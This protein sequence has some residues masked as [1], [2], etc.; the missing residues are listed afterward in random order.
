MARSGRKNVL[1]L[2]GEFSLMT[3]Y[4]LVQDELLSCVQFNEHKE[5]MFEAL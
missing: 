3:V 1:V 2:S 4:E 5:L